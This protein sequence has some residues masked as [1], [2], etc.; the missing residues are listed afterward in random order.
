[1]LSFSSC[2]KDHAS[3]LEIEKE[4]SQEVKKEVK[5]SATFNGITNGGV[6]SRATDNSWE[7]SDAIGL[8]MKTAGVQLTQPALADNVKFTSDGTTSF[9]SPADNKVYYPFNKL[10]VDFI[11]YYP[12]T[13]GLD[14]LNY[15]IDLS[16]QSNLAKLDLMY[17]DN[18]K[19]VNSDLA[20]VNLNMVHQLTKVIFKINT[21]NSGKDLAGLTAKVTNVF[22]K[23]P[24][25][26]IDGTIGTNS[27]RQDV[28][29]K[30]NSEGTLFE[31]IL[32]P[33][34]DLKDNSL[35]ITIG[36]T[37]YTY[38]LSSADIGA[39][40]KS[41]ECEFGITLDAGQGPVLEGVTVTVTDWISVKEDI[42][43]TEDPATPP[44]GESGGVEGGGTSGDESGGDVTPPVKENDDTPPVTADGDGTEA[45]P[46]SIAQALQINEFKMNVWIKGYIVGM[47]TN[48]G[49]SYFSRSIEGWQKQYL[50]VAS[51]V[52]ETDGQKTFPI[53][54]KDAKSLYLMR[55]INLIENPQ[56]LHK[57]IIIKGNIVEVYTADK[58]VSYGLDN[59]NIA[60]ID[61]VTYNPKE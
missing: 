17:S 46:Y 33:D 2:A 11:S 27:A 47:Y 19:A 61:G 35:V 36:E 6:T 51:S 31:A 54:L 1:M 13:T 40:D 22:T 37:N 3:E 49:K 32:M 15:P 7:T 29:L 34:D 16:D 57:E 45:N 5:V 26:L 44:P 38:L 42:T 10:N 50:A 25:S 9:I 23:A 60:I 20:S 41:T 53:R 39:F 14:G 55:V 48:V 24:F 58:P 56:H 8:F 21:N 52:D 43:V 28:S 59:S 4:V 12:Y 18:V 30:V